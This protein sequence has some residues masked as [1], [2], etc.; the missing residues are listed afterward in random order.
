M[1]KRAFTAEDTEK[2]EKKT[3]SC[4]PCSSL[5]ALGALRGEKV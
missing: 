4:L 2:I 5:C 3:L 1:G